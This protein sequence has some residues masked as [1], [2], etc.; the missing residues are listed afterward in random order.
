[1]LTANSEGDKIL[2]WYLTLRSLNF[3]LKLFLYFYPT[4]L[5]VDLPRK[6]RPYLLGVMGQSPPLEANTKVTTLG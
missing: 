3:G 6:V 4:P 1:M 5:D 2:R